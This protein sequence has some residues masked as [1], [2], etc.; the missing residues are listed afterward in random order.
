VTGLFSVARWVVVAGCC[1]EV[2][3]L[4]VVTGRVSFAFTGLAADGLAKAA[5]AGV[6]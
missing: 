6:A 2:P 5:C 3:D 1:V 4:A